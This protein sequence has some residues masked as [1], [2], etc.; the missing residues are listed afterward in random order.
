MARDWDFGECSCF[1][2]GLVLFTN[3]QATLFLES[4]GIWQRIVSVYGFH[5]ES[6]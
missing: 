3:I 5:L 1:H 4:F 6:V 2:L